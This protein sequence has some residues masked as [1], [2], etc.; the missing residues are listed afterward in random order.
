[1][2][3]DYNCYSHLSLS[4]KK[5][6]LVVDIPE[7]EVELRAEPTNAR[8]SSFV[9]TREYLAPEVIPGLGHGSRVEMGKAHDLIR[10]LQVKDPNKRTGGAV[11]IKEAWVFGRCQL[12]SNFNT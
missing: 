4:T 3:K 6:K 1:M 5:N 8:S 7:P 12:A 9:G 10:K 11:E 2:D